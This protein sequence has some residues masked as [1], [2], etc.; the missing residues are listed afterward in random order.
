MS[1]YHL[2][3]LYSRRLCQKFEALLYAFAAILIQ[4]CLLAAIG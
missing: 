4:D 3:H 1:E 2:P